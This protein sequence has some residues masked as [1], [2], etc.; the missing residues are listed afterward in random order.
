MVVMVEASHNLTYTLD[1]EFDQTVA[2]MHTMQRSA[3][4]SHTYT[5]S[6]HPCANHTA[7]SNDP[8]K[9]RCAMHTTEI[10]PAP[11]R[12]LRHAQPAC[13]LHARS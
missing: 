3:E 9:K 8:C 1:L 5:L 11:P 4:A 6:G 2:S 13:P 10:D 12:A 7:L